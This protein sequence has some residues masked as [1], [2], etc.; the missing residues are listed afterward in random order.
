MFSAGLELVDQHQD[1]FLFS[2]SIVNNNL[3][4]FPIISSLYVPNLCL[5]VSTSICLC[6]PPTDLFAFFYDS[7]IKLPFLSVLTI[8]PHFFKSCLFLDYLFLSLFGWR[9]RRRKKFGIRFSIAT[10]NFFSLHFSPSSQRF[11]FSQFFL[12]SF[13]IDVTSCQLYYFVVVLKK[14]VSLY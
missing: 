8:F 9:R 14:E 5:S 12:V 11:V 13:F 6:I 10:F 3:Q 4:F 1:N 2:L 7:P